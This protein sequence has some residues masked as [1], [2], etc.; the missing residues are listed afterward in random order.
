[1][2]VAADCGQFR[3]FVSSARQTSVKPRSRNPCPR[4]PELKSARST[5][6]SNCLWWRTAA[7][8]GHGAESQA[9][10]FAAGHRW[11]GAGLPGDVCRVRTDPCTML[12]LDPPLPNRR[13]LWPGAQR[14]R[15]PCA[16]EVQFLRL[17]FVYCAPQVLRGSCLRC[18]RPALRQWAAAQAACSALRRAV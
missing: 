18:A 13:R 8:T 9:P 7:Q 3:C 14:L 17:S 4:R 6:C 5:K 12:S 2:P 11:S 10:T 16:D 15:P 1:M